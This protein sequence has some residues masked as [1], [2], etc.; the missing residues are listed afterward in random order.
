M[1]RLTRVLRVSLQ[2]VAPRPRA[3]VRVAGP[4]AEDYLQRIS[5]LQKNWDRE[6]EGMRDEITSKARQI[7]EVSLVPSRR[8]I[9]IRRYV[10]VWLSGP[11]D[12]KIR[13]ADAT[14]RSRR[15]RA[16]KVSEP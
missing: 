5:A 11:H 15:P 8:N 2:G 16:A 9:D 3:Y 12:R 7:E 13:S 4:D 1:P 14:R 6:L 10:V